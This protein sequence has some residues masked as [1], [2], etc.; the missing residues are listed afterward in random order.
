ML[1]RTSFGEKCVESIIT[2]TNGFIARHLAIWLDTVLQA[3]ELPT[4]V[5]DLHASLT[6]VNANSLAHA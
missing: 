6:N 3:K 2:A 5:T 4:R 1:A